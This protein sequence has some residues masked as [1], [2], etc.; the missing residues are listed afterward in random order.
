MEATGSSSNEQN[1]APLP[2]AE[3]AAT[4]EAP[5]IADETSSAMNT[6]DII[7]YCIYIIIY[8]YILCIYTIYILYIYTH[9]VYI[10][11]M[12]VIRAILDNLDN[13]TS[14]DLYISIYTWYTIH[15]WSVEAPETWPWR[16]GFHGFFPYRLIILWPKMVKHHTLW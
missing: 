14:Y 8:I 1:Q 2:V 3:A 13:V 16:H 12:Y 11:Y 6:I 5:E 9:Y 10:L 15:G 4:T 7:Y